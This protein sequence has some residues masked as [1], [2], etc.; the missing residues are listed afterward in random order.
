MEST[1]GGFAVALCPKRVKLSSASPN[2]RERDRI[3]NLD[4]KILRI[5]A[6]PNGIWNIQIIGYDHVTYLL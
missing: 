5:E 1:D 3:T 2:E 4:Y 6:N